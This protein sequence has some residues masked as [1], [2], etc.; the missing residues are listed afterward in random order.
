MVVQV[1]LEGAIQAEA[2]KA[3]LARGERGA[4]D[5]VPWTLAQQFCDPGFA[6]LSG[7]RIVRVA[8][9]PDAQ[10]VGYGTRAL[11]LLISYLEGELDEREEDDSSHLMKMNWNRLHSG[12]NLCNQGRRCLLLGTVGAT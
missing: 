10:R 5:L 9:H 1:A 7:A 2:V 3:S 6:K 12:R 11:K 4:G 8:T